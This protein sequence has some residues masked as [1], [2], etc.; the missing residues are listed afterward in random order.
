MLTRI[1]DWKIPC[2]HI[3]VYQITK[4]WGPGPYNSLR[5]ADNRI[6]FSDL[7]LTQNRREGYMFYMTSEVGKFGHVL[8]EKKVTFLWLMSSNMVRP[9]KV[10]HLHLVY[11][12]TVPLDAQKAFSDIKNKQQKC[13]K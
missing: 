12:F 5:Q 9:E 2:V 8:L 3:H 7:S 4:N 6:H 1:T 11:H 10:G 13:M